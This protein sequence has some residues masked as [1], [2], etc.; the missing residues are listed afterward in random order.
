MSSC[1]FDGALIG[2]LKEP[3]L[4]TGVSTLWTDNNGCCATAVDNFEKK[5]VKSALRDSDGRAEQLIKGEAHDALISFRNRLFLESEILKLT[6]AGGPPLSPAAFGICKDR[7]QVS[8]ERGRA[9]TMRIMKNGT[10][11]LMTA[12][13]MDVKKFME[14]NGLSSGM[15]TPQAY[16]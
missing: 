1:L 11:T 15:V 8:T 2:E 10:R 3:L 16:D 9:I 4:I 14:E 6:K 13:S 12:D 7:S 5:F